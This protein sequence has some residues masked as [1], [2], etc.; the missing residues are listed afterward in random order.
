MMTFQEAVHT[1]LTKKYASKVGR[2]SRSEFWWFQLFIALIYFCLVMIASVCDDT[3]VT[4]LAIIGV[5]VFFATIVPYICVFVRRLHDNGQ[6][7]SLFW[8]SFIITIWGVFLLGGIINMFP[9]DKG[10]NEFGPNPL[11]KKEDD[12]TPSDDSVQSPKK[13]ID[14]QSGSTGNNGIEITDVNL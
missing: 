13:T 5:I 10:D 2:A 8:F 12:A 14:I 4:I 9:G 1:C 6:S 11:K 3:C 7:G